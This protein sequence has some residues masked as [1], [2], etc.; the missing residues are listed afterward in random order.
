LRPGMVYVGG[1]DPGLF[2]PMLLNET[3]D[4]ERHIVLTQNA[5]AD[6]SYL[7]YVN[8]TYGDRIATLT[9]DD[10]QDALQDYI[11]DYQKRFAHDQQFPD[12]PRQVFPKE[13]VR[14]IDGNLKPYG[15]ISVMAVNQLLLQNLLQKNPGLSFA[16]EE[17]FPLRSTYADASALGP[18]MELR[19]SDQQ[20]ALTEDTAGQSV[21]YWRGLAQQLL[22]DP[23]TPDGSSVR[24]A[25]AHM[26]EAQANLFANHNL[27]DQAEQAY[28]VADTLW[29]DNRQILGS[30]SELLIREGRMDEANQLLDKFAR[31]YPK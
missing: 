24:K 7:D 27:N 26:A 18:V 17:S 29:P 15:D 4:G 1:S 19:A 20:N 11:A 6:P 21:A 3:R 25:Y 13:D 10:C 16:L 5:L 2:I 9:Q 23:E 8:D 22:S 12:E 30:L 28:R 31:P 14:N